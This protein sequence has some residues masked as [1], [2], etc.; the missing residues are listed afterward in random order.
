MWLEYEIRSPNQAARRIRRQVFDLVGPAARATG[1]TAFSLNESVRLTRSLSLMMRTE[2]LPINCALATEYVGD[3]AGRSLLD[4]RNLLLAAARGEIA[5]GDAQS[6]QLL[7]D[8]KPAFTPLYT[9]ALARL[10]WS[11]HAEQIYIERL[12]VLARHRFFAAAHDRLV[13]REA[14]DIVANEVGVDLAVPD[15]LPIR[16][17]QGVFDTNAERLLQIAGRPVGNTAAAFEATADWITLRARD[18]L[19]Q[20]KI[21]QDARQRISD[22]LATGYSVV[23]SP[24]PVTMGTEPFVGWWRIDSVT[25]DTLGIASTGWGQDMAERGVQYRFFA[26][27]AKQFVFDSL[28][29][30]AMP[31]VTRNAAPMVADFFGTPHPPDPPAQKVSQE[32]YQEVKA[33]A[34]ECM[35]SAIVTGAAFATLPLLLRTLKYI[36]RGMRPLVGLPQIPHWTPKP[37]GIPRPPKPRLPCVR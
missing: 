15:A 8:A 18:D 9:L 2:I 20:L 35:I 13:V 33:T 23:T 28:L 17:N 1:A 22:D 29:C 21:S 4:V 37:R 26:E 31:I 7:N 5:P 3:L 27:M 19:N 14:T 34:S 24:R 12:N 36:G 30:Q 10:Q 16:V 6:D 11:R 25:G 32:S